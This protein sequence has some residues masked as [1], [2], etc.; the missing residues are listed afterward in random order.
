MTS[1]VR[2]RQNHADWTDLFGW[3]FTTDSRALGERFFGWRDDLIRVEEFFDGATEVIRAEVPGIDPVKD[4]EVHVTD[5]M[6]VLRVERREQSREKAGDGAFRTEFRYGELTRV[7]PLPVGAREDA[8]T[9]TYT[10]GILEIRVP[11]E[12]VAQ[13]PGSRRVEVT[14]NE[15]AATAAR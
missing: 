10:D 3:P 12:P 8:I 9:A 2:R 7:L 11:T 13:K 1:I 14:S 4:V 15:P 6:L 5:D